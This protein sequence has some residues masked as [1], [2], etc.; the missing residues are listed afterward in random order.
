MTGYA[1][2]GNTLLFQP[3]VNNRLQTAF[4]PP[5]AEM[6]LKRVRKKEE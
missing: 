5:I 3:S 6:S 1:A 2:I 4:R